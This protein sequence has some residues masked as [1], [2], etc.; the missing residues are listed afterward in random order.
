MTTGAHHSDSTNS[1]NDRPNGNT[2]IMMI[3]RMLVIT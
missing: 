2:R 1:D 3:V